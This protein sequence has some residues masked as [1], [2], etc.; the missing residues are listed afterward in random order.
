MT[1]TS[2]RDLEKSDVS[3]ENFS[4]FIVTDTAGSVSYEQKGG[5]IVSLSAVP[6][7][8]WLP[9]GNAIRIRTA[10]TAV[11]FMVA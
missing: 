9:A 10:S 11:G 3:V 5:N 8:V 7:G 6:V 4:W 2:T 1:I